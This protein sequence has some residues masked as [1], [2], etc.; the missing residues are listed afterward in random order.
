[1]SLLDRACDALADRRTWWWLAGVA[2]FAFPPTVGLAVIAVGYDELAAPAVTLTVATL[3]AWVC[4]VRVAWLLS[5]RDMRRRVWAARA[6]TLRYWREG[7]R[8][9][10]GRMVTIHLPDI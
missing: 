1:M 5:R 9:H 6:S 10:A 2:A 7:R 8:R 3:A 4:C